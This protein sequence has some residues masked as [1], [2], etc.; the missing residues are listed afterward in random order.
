MVVAIDGPAGVGKS[1]I[2]KLLAEKLSLLYINSGYFYR[3]ITKHV[4]DSQRDPHS[5]DDIAASARECSITIIGGRIHCNGTDVEDL[6][7]TDEVDAFVAE[8][9]A[10]L[11]VRHAVNRQLRESAETLDLVAEGRDIATVVF[12]DADYKFYLD[13]DI[14]IRAER[15]HRQQDTKLTREEIAAGIRKRDE[16]DTGKAYGKLEVAPGAVYVDTSHLTIDEVCDKLIQE[17]KNDGMIMQE[18]RKV[19]PEKE[20]DN[21]NTNEMQNVLQEEYL[22]K[23]DDIEEGQLITGHV[24]EITSENV[25]VDV[26]FKSE[27]RIPVEEFEELPSIGDKVQVVLISKEGKNGQTVVSKKKA[28]ARLA[29]NHMREAHKEGLPIKGTFTKE[30][31]GGYEVTIPGGFVAF[32]PLSKADMRRVENPQDMIG[33]TDYFIIDRLHADSRVKPVLSRRAYLEK[34]IERKK[35]E[36]FATRQ[37][38][39]EVEGTVKSF[40]SF[41]AFIDLGGFDGLLH[42]NDMS[43]GHVTRPKDYVKKGQEIQL[44]LIHL[45]PENQKINL[46]LKHFTPDPWES[47][48]DRYDVEDVVKGKVTKITDFGVFIELEEGIEGLAHI[49]E[50]SWIKRISHP[51]EVVSIGD[52]VETMIL[53][54]DTD[55]RRVSLGLKQVTPNPWDTIEQEYPVGKRMSKKVIKVTNAGAFIELEEG[56]DG[57]LHIDDVSW[58]RKPKHM[59]AVCNEGD[60]LEVVITRVDPETRRIRL[61]L[62]QLSDNPW[63]Q[64]KDNYPRGSMIEGEVTSVTD[65]GVFVKVVDGIEGLIPKFSLTGPHEEFTDEVLK[66]F[67]PGDQV[68]AMVMDVNPTAKKLGLSIKDYLKQSQKKE[69]SKYIHS[70]EDDD[71]VITFA[72]LIKDKSQDS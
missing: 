68:K 61:G 21:K 52:D 53:G 17:I 43:W 15:R 30:I 72:D 11:E 59:S 65:F 22:N 4:L 23:L 18:S 32:C 6:L 51:R 48:A 2:A 31:K 35:A 47:F 16:V 13:A 42:I 28:D 3:A 62:K 63:K 36:F 29:A 55:N 34:E 71:D 69:M 14:E 67:N 40:T 46:S 44:K 66:R 60:M 45:D 54:Y 19:G 38:G 9:S 24:V 10:I 57:F 8:H 26:G 1:T 27:G 5:E 64:L 7:Q 58:T 39:D 12:P 33:V 20:T 70:S 50:L 49:S 25:F 37:V 41:G 56:I